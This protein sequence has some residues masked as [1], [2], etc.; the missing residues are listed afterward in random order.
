MCRASI[1]LVQFKGPSVY[2]QM[3]QCREIA[4]GTTANPLIYNH[5]KHKRVMK[6]QGAR[7]C[8]WG[9]G[10]KYIGLKRN[11]IRLNQFYFLFY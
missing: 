1:K 8:V 9:K 6:K 7:G 11:C 3:P 2:D 5:S 4:A 10:D